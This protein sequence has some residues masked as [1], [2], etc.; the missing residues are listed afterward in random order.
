MM[1][2]PARDTA[3][4]LRGRNPR[5]G[6]VTQVARQLRNLQMSQRE[7]R[8]PP[9]FR[10]LPQKEAVIAAVDHITRA[11]FPQRIGGFMGTAAA[12]DHYVHEELTSG[13]SVLEREV[14]TE[15]APS[16]SPSVRPLPAEHDRNFAL[17]ASSLV[18]VRILLDSDIEAAFQRDPA[19][20]S[21]EEILISYPGAHAI[22]WHRIAHEL[23]RLGFPIV[24]RIISEAARERTGIDIHPGAEIGPNFFIDHGTGVVIGETAVIGARVRLYQQV[25]LGARASERAAKPGAVT[26]TPRH[27]QVD[28]DVVIYAGATI[29][30]PVKIGAGAVIA[31]NCWIIDDVPEAAVVRPLP[32]AVLTGK[33]A[34]A[35]RER[36]EGSSPA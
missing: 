32:A 25:T 12:E 31:G 21:I 3:E 35:E 15:A 8:R 2:I 6:D 5:L 13:L 7:S 17:F 22:L 36:L 9:D 26:T 30:G 33:A 19:A 34:D 1:G 11:L 27:P 14:A 23:H 28:D 10:G 24:A 4:P 29:I 20:R 16:S 18:R